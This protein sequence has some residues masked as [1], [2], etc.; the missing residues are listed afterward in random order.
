MYHNNRQAERRRVALFIGGAASMPPLGRSRDIS[1][2]GAYVETGRA[3]QI[4][5]THTVSIVWGDDVHYVQARVVRHDQ[6]GMGITFLQ[7]P[8]EFLRAVEDILGER[9]VEI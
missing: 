9:P 2:S 8:A 1:V 5:S 7:P 4:D 6:E 3:L